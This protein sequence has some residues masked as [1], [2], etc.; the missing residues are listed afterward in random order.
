MKID[1]ERSNIIHWISFFAI[2]CVVLGHCRVGSDAVQNIIFDT[3]C[4][5][6]VPF[7]YLISGMFLSI[8]LTNHSWKDIIQTRLR[9]LVVPYFLWCLIPLLLKGKSGVSCSVDEAFALTTSFPLGNPHLWYLHCLIIFVILATLIWR[10]LAFLPEFSRRILWGVSF[11]SIALFAEYF[12]V[13]TLYGTPTS[14]FYFL[15]GFIFAPLLSTCK[16]A[17]FAGGGGGGIYCNIVENCMVRIS[18]KR[19]LG[20]AHENV[21]QLF[22]DFCGL[23][24]ALG[25]CSL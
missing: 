12:G 13:R 20:D 6:H 11:A 18:S 1:S 24:S 4:Q 10:V 23:G 7:F 9:T 16:M 21:L 19:R 8:S 3:F 25:V 2:A 17:K 15:S 22:D 5:W 14:P